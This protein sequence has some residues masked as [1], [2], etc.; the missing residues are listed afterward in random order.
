MSA[1]HRMAKPCGEHCTLY[2][3]KSGTPVATYIHPGGHRFPND[4]IPVIVA[5]FKQYARP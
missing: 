2:P 5:F 3:S 1:L 4:A